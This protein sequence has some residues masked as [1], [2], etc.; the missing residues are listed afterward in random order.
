MRSV[1]QC[2][3]LTTRRNGFDKGQE[4]LVHVTR[5]GKLADAG[6]QDG[7]RSEELADADTA[8]DGGNSGAAWRTG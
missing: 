6:A 8:D 1:K 4:R 3:L 5:S 7:A 2:G